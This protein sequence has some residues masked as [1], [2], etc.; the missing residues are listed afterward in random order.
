MVDLL[1]L[2][3]PIETEEI[4]AGYPTPQHIAVFMSVVW[5]CFYVKT[6]LPA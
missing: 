6:Q 5:Y 4:A 3:L 2:C 1:N